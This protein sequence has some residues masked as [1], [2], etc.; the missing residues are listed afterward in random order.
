MINIWYQVG[1]HCTKWQDRNNAIQQAKFDF[2]MG[3]NL[4]SERGVWVYGFAEFSPDDPTPLYAR[5]TFWRDWGVRESG[6]IS[7]DGR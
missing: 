5:T 3:H 7:K 4:N 1:N 2:S 6:M